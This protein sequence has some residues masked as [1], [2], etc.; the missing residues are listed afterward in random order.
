MEI[1]DCYR[2]IAER[3][4][5]DQC[6]IFLGAGASASCEYDGEMYKGLPLARD[7]LN[8]FRKVLNIEHIYDLSKY[9]SFAVTG[10]EPLTD[11]IWAITI[12]NY[13]KRFGGLRY[14]YT[15]ASLITPS[16]LKLL[17]ETYDGL[18]IGLH[19]ETQKIDY[20]KL[21][22]IHKQIPIRLLIWEKL[23]NEDFFEFVKTHNI[24]Y[25]LWEMD[26]YPPKSPLNS[27]GLRDTIIKNNNRLKVITWR[28]SFNLGI[29]ALSIK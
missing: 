5:N 19:P 17:S 2:I 6:I 29:I 11:P 4:A 8:T 18:T 26:K 23:A 20:E 22:E 3:L 21:I 24:D 14:L 13:L 27:K 16:L 28:V 7:L 15:N 25:R 1:T 9:E 10:G 12:G